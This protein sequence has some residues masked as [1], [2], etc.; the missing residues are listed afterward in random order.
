MIV[1]DLGMEASFVIKEEEEEIDGQM[2]KTDFQRYERFIDYVPILHGEGNK[3]LLWD[4]TWTF[5]FRR[6]EDGLTEVYH[7]GHRF[8]G[9][10]PIRIIIHLH[11]KFVL[12]ACKQY[13][14]SDAFGSEEDGADDVR[15]EMLSPGVRGA[16]GKFMGCAADDLDWCEEQLD[17]APWA[18]V[19]AVKSTLPEGS[20]AE[21]SLKRTL[22]IRRQASVARKI[23]ASEDEEPQEGV[24]GGKDV[25]PK[26]YD[27]IYAGMPEKQHYTSWVGYEV[28]NGRVTA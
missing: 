12:W 4:Q 20:I 22:S 8:Y 1:Q 15:E 27:P 3:I 18:V 14:T 21:R 19:R 16:V 25:E 10:W 28:E 2:V 24:V 6:T 17:R 7:R 23:K 5:G 9:P 13:I 11:Q 26:V